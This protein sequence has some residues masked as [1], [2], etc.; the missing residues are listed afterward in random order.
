MLATVQ[1]LPYIAGFQMIEKT[2]T[3]AYDDEIV[4]A[5]LT[6]RTGWSVTCRLPGGDLLVDWQPDGPV[7]LSGP[8]VEVFRGDWP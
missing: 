6:G 4:A 1:T 7:R 8:A 2:Q 3:F 5:V